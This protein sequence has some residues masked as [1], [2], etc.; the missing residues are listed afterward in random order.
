MTDQ[1]SPKDQEAEIRR[2]AARV[3]EQA[4]RIAHLEEHGAGPAT[5]PIARR[6]RWGRSLSL[7]G[8]L[9]FRV[10]DHVA[11]LKFSLPAAR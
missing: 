10:G 1:G 5:R 7:I 4:S 9:P 8:S 6:S 2:L 11:E 3:A